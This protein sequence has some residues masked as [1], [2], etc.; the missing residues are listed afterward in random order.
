[1][2]RTIAY[3]FSLMVLVSVAGAPAQ[4]AGEPQLGGTY[5]AHGVNPD[6]SDDEQFVQIMRHG[7]SFVVSWILAD[8]SNEAVVLE[9]VSVGIGIVSGSVLA[10]SFYSPSTAGVA[11]FRIEEDGRQLVGQWTAEADDGTIHSQTLTRLPDL[12]LDSAAR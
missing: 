7:D 4:A 11:A 3:A 10:V 6:G 12:T 5:I 1:M 9:L 2:T 8:V